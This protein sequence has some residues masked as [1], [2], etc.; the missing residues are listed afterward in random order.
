MARLKL[1]AQETE[2]SVNE[3]QSRDFERDAAFERADF[4]PGREEKS[5]GGDQADAGA[6]SIESVDEIE[7]IGRDQQPAHGEDQAQEEGTGDAKSTPERTIA[8]ARIWPNE[9]EARR[10][11]EKIVEGCRW[12]R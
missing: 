2:Q 9:L 12:R 5:G 1:P 8:E 7:G 3:R 4:K 10:E 6:E 11:V